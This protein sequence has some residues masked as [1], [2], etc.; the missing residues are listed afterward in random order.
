MAH[1]PRLWLLIPNPSDAGL[2]PWALLSTAVNT[3]H[4]FEQR[5]KKQEPGALAYL[6]ALG[7]KAGSTTGKNK[8]KQT[9]KPNMS[10]K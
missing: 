4:T 7:S 2:D 1:A 8:N 5:S 3:Q 6:K 9:K 10:E